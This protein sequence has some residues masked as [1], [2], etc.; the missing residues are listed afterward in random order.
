MSLGDTSATD[1]QGGAF[2][3]L[4][5]GT[6]GEVRMSLGPRFFVGRECQG[7]EAHQRFII[8]D[9]S[10]QVSRIHFEI[11]VEAALG[12]AVI[13]DRSTNGTWVD[14]SRI[15]PIGSLSCVPRSGN[16]YSVNLGIEGYRVGDR[17]AVDSSCEG[18][19]VRPQGDGRTH[20]ALRPG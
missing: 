9:D 19:R 20:A 10:L 3:V 14:G 6:P 16:E 12:R 8:D 1:A 13:I 15:E 18:T 17:V 4:H 7:I 11:H 2:L 5:A